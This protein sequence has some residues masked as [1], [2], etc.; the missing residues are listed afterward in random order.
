MEDVDDRQDDLQIT[1]GQ[2]F[3]VELEGYRTPSPGGVIF[4]DWVHEAAVTPIES[5]ASRTSISDYASKAVRVNAPLYNGPE[6]SIFQYPFPKKRGSVPHVEPAALL[7]ELLGEQGVRE[8]ETTGNI[9]KD[10]LFDHIAGDRHVMKCVDMEF[11]LN[12]HHH[13]HRDNTSRAHLPGACYMLIQQIYRQD[14]IG[15]QLNVATRPDHHTR[16]IAF[17]SMA[18]R[19][20]E[21]EDDGSLRLDLDLAE[22]MSSGIG[23]NMIPATLSLDDEANNRCAVVVEGFHKG[24]RDWYEILES[25]GTAPEK[26]TTSIGCKDLYSEVDR[27]HWG[28][29]APM[30]AVRGAVRMTLS[31]V[32]RGTAGRDGTLRRS[33][34]AAYIAIQADG[35]TLENPRLPTRSRIARWNR[36]RVLPRCEPNGTTFKRAVITDAI[37]FA[38]LIS[39]VTPVGDALLGLRLWDDWEVMEEKNIL[40]GVDREAAALHSADIRLRLVQA[41]L[42]AMRGLATR[43]RELYGMNAFSGS[44]SSIDRS[45]SSQGEEDEDDEE[46]EGEYEEDD[47]RLGVEVDMDDRD[48]MADE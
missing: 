42:R 11:A 15:Y 1:T 48:T 27:A 17:P 22:Y 41:Y 20:D 6:A 32:L 31:T 37:P 45:D 29:P 23:A 43:E 7:L 21:A 12:D 40:L 19:T 36:S 25:R 34:D 38:G 9:V 30:P 5:E 35:E 24:I 10:G 33:I 39:G 47:G 28:A 8:W 26:G 2:K 13:A 44:N 16:L 46:D 18:R 14:P 4:R 3:V